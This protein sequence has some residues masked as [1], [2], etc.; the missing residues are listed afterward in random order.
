[1]VQAN[2]SEFEFPTGIDAPENAPRWLTRVGLATVR[3]FGLTDEWMARRPWD[4]IRRAIE[5]G[6]VDLTWT[7]LFFGVCY[8]VA[9]S[10]SAP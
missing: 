2:A 10:R 1:M 7:E 3:P 4:A 5:A 9:G 6:L 8:L